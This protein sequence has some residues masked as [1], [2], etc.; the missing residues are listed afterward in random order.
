M[1]CKHKQAEPPPSH[2]KQDPVLFQIQEF[3]HIFK[4]LPNPRE[5]PREKLYDLHPRT[6]WNYT[7]VCRTYTEDVS[8]FDVSSLWL[9]SPYITNRSSRSSP[10]EISRGR[11]RGRERERDGP[12]N[13][14]G[15]IRASFRLTI[16]VGRLHSDLFGRTRR[17][18]LDELPGEFQIVVT[19]ATWIG[20]LT[21]IKLAAGPPSPFLSRAFPLPSFSLPRETTPVFDIPGNN[22]INF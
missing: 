21:K 8:R 13:L 1:S 22:I 9:I 16:S 11:E 6:A 5:T 7:R 15:K 10:L 4:S 17:A 2:R 20:S 14:E 12:S 19:F 18:R 3:Q